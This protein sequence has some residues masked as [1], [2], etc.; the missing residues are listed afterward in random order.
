MRL[1]P[2]ATEC[3][4]L[5]I[6]AAVSIGSI[7]YEEYAALR[8]ERDASSDAQADLATGVLRLKFGG[9]AQPWR[10]TEIR[11]FR[12]REGIEIQFVYGCCPTT[13]QS[14]YARTYNDRVVRDIQ[15]RKPSFSVNQIYGDARREWELSYAIPSDDD[16]AR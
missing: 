1:R 11:L 12:E 16:A 4:A 5:A 10:S 2:T 15:M 8:A 14:R 7:A 9:K 13:Y 3:L 6:A